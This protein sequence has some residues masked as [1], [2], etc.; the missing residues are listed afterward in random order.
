MRNRTQNPAPP[1][2]YFV[3]WHGGA[4]DPRRTGAN[5]RF[6]MPACWEDMEALGLDPLTG[7]AVD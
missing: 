3:P 7:K 4:D 2:K 6:G 5:M 1:R